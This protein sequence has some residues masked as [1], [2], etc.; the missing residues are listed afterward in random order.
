MKNSEEI[1]SKDSVSRRNFIGKTM[2]A[3]AGIAASSVILG[4]MQNQA[5]AQTKS[6]KPINAANKDFRKLGSL[7]V[8]PIGLGCMSMVAGFYNPAPPKSEMIRQIRTAVEGSA[9]LAA[10]Q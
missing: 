1:K 9:Y 8:S 2:L 4:T 5:D 10:R 3:G 7:E 6:S